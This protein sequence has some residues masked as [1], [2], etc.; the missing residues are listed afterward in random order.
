[1]TDSVIERE[2]VSPVETEDVKKIAELLK[3]A[4]LFDKWQKQQSARRFSRS[5]RRAGGFRPVRLVTSGH[6]DFLLLE[7]EREGVTVRKLVAQ[8]EIVIGK[9]TYEQNIKAIAAARKAA[10]ALFSA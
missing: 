9:I 7:R 8:A 5:K 4:E 3:V 2:E 1:M 10:Y 6:Y